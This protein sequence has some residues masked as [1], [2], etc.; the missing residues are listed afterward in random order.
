ME[1]QGSQY[2]CSNCHAVVFVPTKDL[3]R[4]G[5][6]EEFGKPKEGAKGSVD[7][8]SCPQCSFQFIIE[9]PPQTPVPP[10]AA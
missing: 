8:G 7:Y 5:V 1:F 4:E 10:E 6:R 9:L 3:G 2:A